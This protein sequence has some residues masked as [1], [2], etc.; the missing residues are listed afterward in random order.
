[1]M[2]LC[3]ISC[4]TRLTRSLGKKPR[5]TCSLTE[6]TVLCVR[7][8]NRVL[9]FMVR[10]QTTAGFAMSEK[11]KRHW[12]MCHIANLHHFSLFFPNNLFIFHWL[13]FE[14]LTSVK[15]VPKYG[16]WIPW[17]KE[18]VYVPCCS[19]YRSV[20]FSTGPGEPLVARRNKWLHAMER[21]G[22]GMIDLELTHQVWKTR[23]SN[24]TN[25]THLKTINESP[26]PRPNLVETLGIVSP[27]WIS[28]SRFKCSHT[29]VWN[30]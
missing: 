10:S 6:P 21:P 28:F 24:L 16:F 19:D 17:K 2:G 22:K 15:K 30:K 13:R 11:N 5:E 9:K 14:S 20:R 18:F 3:S 7:K 26:L 1:M 23:P 27:M 4:L 25:T 12:K 29:I 8:K